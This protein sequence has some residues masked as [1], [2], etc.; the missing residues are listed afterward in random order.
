MHFPILILLTKLRKENCVAAKDDRLI[1]VI[2]ITL[3]WGNDAWDA[4]RT[5][6]EMFS[7]VDEHLKRFLL[8]YD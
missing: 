1:P 2:T 6:R 3:Y 5:L 4:P 7:E 8:D